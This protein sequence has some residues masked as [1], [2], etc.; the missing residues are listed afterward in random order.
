MTQC[1]L[2]PQITA[3]HLDPPESTLDWI[4]SLVEGYINTELS[5][6]ICKIGADIT[7]QITN[8][9]EVPLNPF[10][11]LRPGALPIQDWS[12]G[13]CVTNIVRR[14]PVLFGAKINVDEPAPTG[15]ELNITMLDALNVTT[16]SFNLYTPPDVIL[17]VDLGL[18]MLVCDDAGLDCTV[19][20]GIKLPNLRTWGGGQTDRLMN[21]YVSPILSSIVDSLF[22]KNG[23]K[24]DIGGDTPEESP[25]MVMIII[26]GPAMAILAA[27]CVGYSVYRHTKNP[28]AD[29]HGKPLKLHR[30]IAEDVLVT[31]ICFTCIYLFAWSNATTAASVV[32]GDELTVYT[33]SLVNSVRGMWDAGLY[34]LSI[35]IAL[36]SGVYPYIKLLT[37]V[38]FSVILQQPQ[39]KFLR[40]VD[41][42]GKFSFLDTFVMTILKTGLEIN[43]IATVK[44]HTSFYIF[45]FATVGSVFVGNYATHGWRRQTQVRYDDNERE[46][47]IQRTSVNS[48]LASKEKRSKGS[49]SSA[50][51]ET[52]IA[53]AYVGLGY[54]ANYDT[55]EEGAATDDPMRY[56]LTGNKGLEGIDALKLKWYHVWE[57]QLAVP[58]GLVVLAISCVACYYPNVTYH[59]TGFAT[60]L[61]GNER[62]S[63][64]WDLFI[65]CDPMLLTV[66]LFT[67]VFSPFMYI[68]TYPHCRF[69]A[70]WGATDVFLLACV[71]ALLQL[72]QFISFTLGEGMEGLYSASCSLEWPLILW[73]LS[74][75]VQWFFVFKQ[76][77]GIP[78]VPT[79]TKIRIAMSLR[80]GESISS[81]DEK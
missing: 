78:G 1:N 68:V 73:T 72:K 69:L 34:P 12:I 63:S 11:P 6:T 74:M 70:A 61:T 46:L 20:N 19:S 51:C 48:R 2:A 23:V 9:T 31:G 29:I 44:C 75:F 76:T 53:N 13:K 22:A 18:D 16:S 81:G 5:S 43:G 54:G 79:L 52:G 64:L 59:I 25:P 27:A 7:R 40:L 65:A 36:F 28:I 67:V 66:G 17:S 15:L 14:L 30:V 33:F 8:N 26:M 32:V 21:N 3:L 47:V 35:L 71:A 57:W 60:V 41:N 38:A 55:A 58:C 39:N 50:N 45:L 37:I 10:P 80:D 56:F 42:I 49:D 62:S 4:L 77:L 24:I